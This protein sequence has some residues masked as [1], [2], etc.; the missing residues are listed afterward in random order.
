MVHFTCL[1]CAYMMRSIALESDDVWGEV[2]LK[3]HRKNP[4]VANEAALMALVKTCAKNH[5]LDKGR[6]NRTRQSIIEEFVATGEETS[7]AAREQS[8]GYDAG[9]SFRPD[10]ILSAAESLGRLNAIGLNDPETAPIFQ[11]IRDLE[12]SGLTPSIANLAERLGRPYANVRRSRLRL[13]EAIRQALLTEYA[14]AKNARLPMGA[15]QLP[16]SPAH[17]HQKSRVT[18]V[19][20][21]KHADSAF[22]K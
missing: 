14:G 10:D 15:K 18:S 13:Q 9:K 21:K 12:E 22:N 7:D 20:G 11:A 16:C 17:P 2:Y 8:R 6:K 1:R 19:F 3:L 5:I 4:L